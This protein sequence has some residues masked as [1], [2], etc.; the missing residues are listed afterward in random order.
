[1]SRV[2]HFEI[3]ATDLTKSMK[4]YSDVF[5]WKFT[6]FGNQDYWLAETGP[7]DEVGI[8]GAVMK[9]RDPNQPMT[10]SISVSNLDRAIN[11]ISA[12]GGMMVVPKMA[13]PGVGWLAFFKDPDGIIVGVWQDDQTAK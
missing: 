7:A 1:M 13:I 6:R 2:T 12:A 10:N 8:N 11:K 9:R 3:P 4:F 5:G